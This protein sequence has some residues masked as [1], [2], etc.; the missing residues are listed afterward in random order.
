MSTEPQTLFEKVWKQHIVVEPKGEP[1]LFDSS[2]SVTHFDKFPAGEGP[3]SY[4]SP[5]P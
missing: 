1:T 5:A 4:P 3:P 2:T